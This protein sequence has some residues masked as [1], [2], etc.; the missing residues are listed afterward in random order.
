M[1]PLAKE[2]VH[3]AQFDEHAL[4]LL[5]IINQCKHKKR[6]NIQ[7]YKKS[8]KLQI[9]NKVLLMNSIN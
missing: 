4:F 7:Y 9:D 5:Y 6:Y 3:E 1:Q 2:E 8:N